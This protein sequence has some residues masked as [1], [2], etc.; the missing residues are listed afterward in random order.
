HGAYDPG[1]H[2]LT[3]WVDRATSNALPNS[4]SSHTF[5][6]DDAGLL[7]SHTYPTVP[8]YLSGTVRPAIGFQS[9]ER[10]GLIDPNLTASTGLGK[11]SN[12]ALPAHSAAVRALV[13]DGNG[14]V[15]AYA[16][17]RFY[18]PVT[19]EPPHRGITTMTR[20]ADGRV[21]EMR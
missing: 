10:L 19:I 3:S 8:I 2:A 17:D 5:L 11:A 20:D 1:S 16:V 18:A 12:P 7:A 15:T 14:F 6:Y 9:I 21:T 13:A 4:S